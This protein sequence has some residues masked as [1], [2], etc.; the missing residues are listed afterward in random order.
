MTLLEDNVTENQASRLKVLFPLPLPR[1]FDYLG[2][3]PD[4]P[5]IGSFV[6]AEFGPRRIWGVV[7]PVQ[8]D[9]DPIDNSRLK[10]IEEI[11]DV[12]P[13]GKPVIDFV[14]WVSNYSMYPLGSVL[15]LVIRSGEALT[16]PKGLTG[17]LFNHEAVFK[18]TEARRRIADFLKDKSSA[19]TAREI[20]EAVGV[21]DGVVRGFEK[22]GGLLKQA[23]DPDP[24]FEVPSAGHSEVVLSD[25]QKNAAD[26]IIDRIKRGGASVTLIDGVTGSGKTEVYL[27]AI[28]AA[29]AKNPTSQILLML[30]EIALTLPFL[31]RVKNRFGSAPA[32]WHSDMSGA[33]RRRVW[34]RVNEGQARLIVGARSALF[35]PY[36]DLS[37][38]IV[39]EEHENAYKQEDGVIYHGRDMAVLRGARAKF[40][41]VL[42]SATPSLETVINVDQGRYEIERLKKRFGSAALPKIVTI[43]M[44]R[45]G[46]EPDYWLSP[47]LVKEINKRIAKQEQSL[48]FL[49]RRGYAPLTICRQC[50]H[51]MK[52]PDSDTWLVE[53]R[54]EK[55]LVC[56]HTGFSM[57][58]PDACPTCKAVGALTA[59]GPGVE[60]VAEEAKRQW[61]EAR[62]A[63]LSSDLIHSATAMRE[64]LDGMAKGEFDILVATQM[65]AKGHHFPKLTFVGVVDADMGLAGGDLRAAERT[66]QMISQV[67]GRAG[68]EI[69]EGRSGGLAMLQSYEPGAAVL[70]SLKDNDRD[71]F[72]AAEAAGREALGFPPFGRLAAIILKS[73][74]ERQLNQ[75]VRDHRAALI[76]AD[77]VE[78]WGPAP[79]PLYRLR[80]LLRIRFL[81]KARRDVNIQ[82]F[83]KAWLAD[84]KIPSRVRRTIDIDPYSFL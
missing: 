65:V 13:L 15:R 19:M 18:E 74:D 59:C 28:A 55:K 67:A 52:S 2:L 73:P 72:L 84:L 68:R 80:G 35:L 43:D 7:W 45:D 54:F 44:R 9:F 75:A 51:R 38:I 71:A 63:V 39:D 79:A 29:L 30:P 49:N 64:M 40:P 4:A 27:E 46:P 47:L 23:I 56:H 24:K 22:T 17:Y 1:A 5:P 70:Q 81:V 41:V 31:E 62:L 21:S 50:G 61:P 34:R 48:L 6:K 3:T 42:A 25:E 11:V 53:H 76:N 57:P 58:K 10:T 8:G 20:A 66:Y 26:N 37:L 60:R 69:E 78:V 14:E 36:K 82:A 16:P 77:G 33:A 12:P 32:G 83:L